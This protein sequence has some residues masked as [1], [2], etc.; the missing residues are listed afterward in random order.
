MSTHPV[1]LIIDDQLTGTSELFYSAEAIF[2]IL[3]IPIELLTDYSSVNNYQDRVLLVYSKPNFPLLRELEANKIKFIWVYADDFFY[4][5]YLQ[6]NLVTTIYEDPETHIVAF[7]KNENNPE[8]G[9]S[10][11]FSSIKISYDIFATTFALLSL[12]EEF[13]INERDVH[14]RFNM[15]YSF[16]S[17]FNLQQRAVIHEYAELLKSALHKLYGIDVEVAIS[18]SVKIVIGI[19]IDFKN[20]RELINIGALDLITPSKLKWLRHYFKDPSDLERLYSYFV[21]LK[22]TASLFVLRNFHPTL[23]QPFEIEHKTLLKWNCRFEVGIHGSYASMGNKKILKEE[24]NGMRS[25]LSNETLGIRQHYLRWTP[26]MWDM[27]DELGLLYNS[28]VT[29]NYKASGLRN[30][31][32]VPYRVYS[33]AKKKKLRLVEFPIIFSDQLIKGPNRNHSELQNAL[34]NW[35][36]LLKLAKRYS[37]VITIMWHNTTFNC[38]INPSGPKM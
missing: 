12:Y 8:E 38:L 15:K 23:D 9:I 28:S 20:S 7:W 5:D 31:I 17:T 21:N 11:K 29:N 14:G 25:L 10:Y 27:F 18:D 22:L 16:A 1:F 26:L 30:G 35:N 19:D 4:T 34:T 2:G 36:V 3:G 33:I 24:V 13:V 37:G 32:I 6:K